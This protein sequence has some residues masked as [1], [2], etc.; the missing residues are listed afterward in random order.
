MRIYSA[1][2]AFINW[3]DLS[4]PDQKFHFELVRALYSTP[5]SIFVAV[6]VAAT[7]IAIAAGLS[8]DYVYGLFLAAFLMVGAA[9]TGAVALYQR[10]QH[11][12]N[13]PVST[14]R[15]ELRALLGAWTFAT[16]VG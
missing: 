7:I 5:N 13:D 14:K 12:P 9:R 8:S 10:T 11:D 15:W 4:I 2:S 3:L 16:L 1:E 6:I